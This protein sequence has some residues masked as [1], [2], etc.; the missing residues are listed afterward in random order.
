[1]T[2]DNDKLETVL[3]IIGNSSPDSKVYICCE[4]KQSGIGVEFNLLARGLNPSFFH[5]EKGVKY[6]NIQIIQIFPIFGACTFHD[7]NIITHSL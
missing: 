2:T 6:E 5:E 1:M 7:E 4:D 3:N